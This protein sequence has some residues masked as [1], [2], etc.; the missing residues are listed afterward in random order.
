[1][2]GVGKLVTGLS[3][4]WIVWGLHSSSQTNDKQLLCVQSMFVASDTR[5]PVI[6]HS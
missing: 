6:D 3:M 2:H 5:M 4:L 1:M